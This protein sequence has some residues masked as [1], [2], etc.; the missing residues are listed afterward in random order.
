MKCHFAALP[1]NASY[2]ILHTAEVHWKYNKLHLKSKDFANDI[3]YA[4]LK[5]LFGKN[6]SPT[7]SPASHGGNARARR[8]SHHVLWIRRPLLRDEGRPPAQTAIFRPVTVYK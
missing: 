7:M 5:Q 8:H 1:V 2:L 4:K 3:H 6:T